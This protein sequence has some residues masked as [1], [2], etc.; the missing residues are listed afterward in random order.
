MWPNSSRFSSVVG[1]LPRTR[2]ELSP[3]PMPS[4]MRPWE[5][6]LRVAKR[7]AEP[8]TSRTAGLVTQV[9]RRIVFVL[10]AMSVRSGNGSFQM[11]WESKIQPKEKPLDSAWRVRLRIRSIEMSGLMVMPK[12]M[13]KWS[14]SAGW[15]RNRCN[16]V[17]QGEVNKE[18]D[19]EADEPSVVVEDTHGGNGQTY[20]GNAR[21]RGQRHN[22]GPIETA[23][24][25]IPAIALIEIFDEEDFFAHDEV[26][27]DED[28]RDGS[29]K[30]GVTD[31]PAEN[32]AAVI[33]Q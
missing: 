16:A 31:E 17:H 15:L 24:I 27:A 10:E 13:E 33:G 23:R 5:A 8:V 11:T 22:G 1:F 19:Q 2:R 4:S 3:R 26:I 9:P 12:S 30:A 29:Q 28:A 21:A 32:V 6:R 7:L 18:A 14:S 20:E 25:F